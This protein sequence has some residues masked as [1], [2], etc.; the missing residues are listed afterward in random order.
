MDIFSKYNIFSHIRNSENSFILNPLTGSADIVDK[1]EAKKIAEVR[2]GD[3][4]DLHFIA[5]LK[6]KGYVM[7]D[8][9]EKKLFRSRY[10][11]FIDS[12]EK[13]D[14]QLFY[15]PNYSCNFSCAYC[16]QDQYSNPVKKESKDTIQAFLRY[17]NTAFA[18]RKKYVTLFGGEPLLNSPEQKKTI[19]ELVSALNESGI[20]LCVV[21]N[22]YNLKDYIHILKGCRIR[23]I[24]V[25]LDGTEEIHN[26]RRFLKNKSGT[27]SRIV[28]GIDS[29]LEKNLPVNLRMVTDRENIENLP[30][31]ARFAIDKGWTKHPLFK[32][33]LGRN[34]ELHHCQN[35]SGKL[36]DRISLYERIYEL[37]RV[38]PYI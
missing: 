37:A 13:D 17:V 3:F 10:L 15:V 1:I 7:D 9:D 28:E 35:S 30:D 31:F 25:T 4:S 36:F 29:C 16:Y 27:F 23:E 19:T 26:S 6:E 2:D 24:Q 34:Y 8:T 21:T 14:I 11:D 5:Q 32:S 18:G 20:D 33:Q 22:G 38:H 12:R